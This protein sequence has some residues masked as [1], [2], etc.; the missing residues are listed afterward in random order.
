[1]G[2]AARGAAAKLERVGGRQGCERGVEGGMG[3]ASRGGS[4]PAQ[5]GEP[6]DDELDE[7]PAGFPEPG[8]GG[9]KCREPPV[10]RP[11]VGA[12]DPRPSEGRPRIR[13]DSDSGGRSQ[14]SQPVAC[15]EFPG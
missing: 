1:M 11:R 12:G 15:G 4:R 8:P 2:A 6:D 5:D 9:G 3:G 7:P 10:L 13:A 14:E